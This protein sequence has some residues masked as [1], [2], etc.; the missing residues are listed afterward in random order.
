MP[1]S[2]I[3]SNAVNKIVLAQLK[4]YADPM[5]LSNYISP[6]VTTKRTDFVYFSETD[7]DQHVIDTKVGFDTPTP[8]FDWGTAKGTGK[9][10]ARRIGT[11]IPAE[12]EPDDDSNLID[13]TRM[14]TKAVNGIHRSR[15]YEIATWMTTE[16]NFESANVID[17]G[18]TTKKWGTSGSDPQHDVRDNFDLIDAHIE[19]DPFEPGMDVVMMATPDVDEKIRS[20][21]LGQILANIGATDLAARERIA[22]H[23]GVREYRV[24]G[25]AYNSAAKG[26]GSSTRT[27]FFGTNK[28][29]F[30]ASS[31]EPIT[32]ST[33]AFKFSAR[34]T[35]TDR[36]GRPAMSGW[37]YKREDPPADI[38]VARDWI[39]DITPE[40]GACVCL[41]NV[42]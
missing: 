4:K 41:K 6:I 37:S 18:A 30:W 7:E 27:R 36:Q 15:M 25:G 32:T 1:A 34:Y 8:L 3:S 38:V 11:V 29:W 14:L 10:I 23:F 26:S 33:P 31:R 17:I 39:G 42:I 13:V 5:F 9:A 35:G 21:H 12:W 19:L 2:T 28:V 20:Y 16:S 40:N 24:A 22:G